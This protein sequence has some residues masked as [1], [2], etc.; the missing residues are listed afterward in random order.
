MKATKSQIEDFMNLPSY[1]IIGVS[2]RKKKFGNE[3]LKQMM[4]RGMEVY[5]VHRTAPAVD[6]VKCYHNLQSLPEKPEGVI[7]CVP[8]EQ[9]EKIVLEM[10]NAGISH[11]WMQHGS[12]SEAA[13]SYCI[14]RGIKIVSGECVIMFLKNL[15]FPHGLHKRIWNIVN[16]ARA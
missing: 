15:G 14:S 10:T 1:A 12:S 7:A 5:P 11:I 16:R 3:I 9:T 13:I 8:P 6:G 2:A 4:K